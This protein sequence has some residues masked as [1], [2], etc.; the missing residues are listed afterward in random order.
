MDEVGWNQGIYWGKIMFGEERQ[1]HRAFV[2][3]YTTMKI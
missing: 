1:Q 2:I 3:T